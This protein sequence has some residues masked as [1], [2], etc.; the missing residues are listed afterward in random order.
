MLE[1]TISI[2]I[3]TCLG[4]YFNIALFL[5]T[6]ILI[7]SKKYRKY[8]LFIF[9]IFIIV[10]LGEIKYEKLNTYLE[11]PKNISFVGK[12]I[13]NKE[14]KEY[15][16][17]YIIKIKK[18]DNKDLENIKLI[19]YTGKEKTYSYGDVLLIDGN[20]LNAQNARNRNG[21]DYSRFLRQEKIYGICE[22]EKSQFLENERDLVFY[23]YKFKTYCLERIDSEY[24]EEQIGFLKG[25]LLGDT[26][27]LD[28][29]I[30]S[31][32]QKSNLSHILAISGMHIAYIVLAVDFIL[33]K[34]IVS[35]KLQYILEIIFVM[36]FAIFT[37]AS[38]SCIRAAV[39]I[40]FTLI[41]KL[42]YRQKDFY[43]NLLLAFSFLIILN[44]YNIEA[45]GMWLSFLGTL[46]LYVFKKNINGY[47]LNSLFVSF[48]IQ[49][50]IFPVVV[51]FY[52]TISLTFFI[53][54]LLVGIIIGPI[55]ILGYLSLF[56]PKISIIESII[57]KII[58]KVSEFVSTLKFSQ[59]LVVTP[60][61]IL[62]FFYYIVIAL[63]KTRSITK[64]RFKVL[65]LV[66]IIILIFTSLTNICIGYEI[67][68]IDVGQGDST[69]ILLPNGKNI[70]IDGGDK[71]E[72][73]DYGEKVLAPYL[74]DRNIIKID[75][76]IISHFDSDH[77]GGLMYIAKNFKVENI[78]IGTQFEKSDN[79]V[80]LF[81]IIK[82]KDINLKVLEKGDNICFDKNTYMQVFFPVA[83]KEI[84]ENS[85]NNNSLVFKLY[86]DEISILFTGDIEKEAEEELVKLYG[87][88]LNA[89]ILKVAHH[90][91]NT[92][93]IKEIIACINP[94]LALIGVG[95]D[96]NFGHP[97]IYVLKNLE[98]IGCKIY[99]TDLNGEISIKI[100]N[101]KIN[102]KTMNN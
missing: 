101:K 91:S 13:S 4:L 46:G 39:M 44:P 84:K 37:G 33:G 59:I 85:I 90:G 75:Y 65:S 63:F 14:E 56:L 78:F 23:I 71:S 21:F 29:K 77:V 5:C 94:K 70:L 88:K 18:C 80:E 60:N 43:S 28:D 11:I 66:L 87:N 89:D 3:G 58:L 25:I 102:I 92:S 36:F 62:I 68:F 16:N 47:I 20:I 19:L 2:L 8:L 79:L 100:K 15:V 72:N 64:N 24:E 86:L 27:E 45:V 40:I 69:L 73:Y 30:K 54:N 52:N 17:K 34:V 41:S 38:A 81:K 96:N 55:I 95:K 32:F 83:Q 48:S 98:S 6:L 93:S 7:F 53:S 67:N 82:E 61:L 22:E 12:V 74:L 49:L 31:D 97:N 26:Y 42:I 35:K 57:I 99:R 50:M 76:M 51:Y 1:I 9:L 10:Y